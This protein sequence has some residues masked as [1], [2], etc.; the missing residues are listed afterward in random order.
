MEF[1]RICISEWK[2]YRLFGISKRLWKLSS[3]LSHRADFSVIQ[4]IFSFHTSLPLFRPK[5]SCFPRGSEGKKL[6]QV[7]GLITKPLPCSA[8]RIPCFSPKP[9]RVTSS[10]NAPVPR[11]LQVRAILAAP[12][13]LQPRPSWTGTHL[14][15]PLHQGSTPG[16]C[17][18]CSPAPAFCPALRRCS[19]IV[20]RN[21]EWRLSFFTRP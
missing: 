17:H 21:N 18:P 12:C 4:M 8:W 19:V 13:S 14:P 7:N 1:C 15:V 3:N 20:C 10:R 6:L 2:K 16:S 9:Y 11:P 5:Y